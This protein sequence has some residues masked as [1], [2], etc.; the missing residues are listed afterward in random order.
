MNPAGPDG[1]VVAG[2]AGGPLACFY[3]SLDPLEHSVLDYAGPD[4]RHVVI[5]PVGPFRTLSSSGCHPAGPAGPY[6]AGGPVGPDDFFK[7]LEPLDH[8]VL[9]HADPAGQHAIVQDTLEPLEHSV[10]DT[11]L[12]CRPMEG[13]THSEPLEHTVLDMTLDGGL[14]EKMSDWEPVAHSFL[15]TT[16]DGRP[17]EGIPDPH[18]LEKSGLVMA[19]DSDLTKG[20]SGLK[21][22]EHSVMNMD[23]DNNI[24]EIQEEP[25]FGS[26]RGWSFLDFTDAM[27][28]EALKIRS[29]GRVPVGRVAVSPRRIIRVT[30]I[31]VTMMSIQRVF[32]AGTQIRMS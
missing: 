22:L 6:V 8:S 21:P 2:V 9:D 19:L 24:V 32:D 13:I 25:M 4:D 5:G 18:P 3:N 16:L 28:E 1:P 11:I 29:A 27:P 26:D 30:M 15:D 7:V 17:M 14:L 23:V 31:C 10:L 12:D 20:I